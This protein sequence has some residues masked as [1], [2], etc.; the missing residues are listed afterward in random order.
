MSFSAKTAR[1]V[2]KTFLRL[3]P[4]RVDGG[5]NVSHVDVH[6]DGPLNQL[7]REHYAKL[8][9][10][11]QENPDKS[12]QRSPDDANATARHQKR[13]RL[14]TQRS[15]QSDSQFFQVLFGQRRG[16][17]IGSDE[18]DDAGNFQHL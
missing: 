17:S 3:V 8:S 18:A 15:A 13:V 1:F 10:S 11:P 4:A 9:F 7:E 6:N 5:H 2:G 16:M 14:R 12:L